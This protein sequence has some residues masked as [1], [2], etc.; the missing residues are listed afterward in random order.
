MSPTDIIIRKFTQNDVSFIKSL[1]PVL[2]EQ[3]RLTWHS[4]K[5]M[6]AFQ[7][8]YI[9]EMLLPT[10]L[11]NITL[12]AEDNTQKLGFVHVRER[13]DEISGE[14]CATVPLLAVVRGLQKRGIGSLLMQEAEKWALG[15]DF[16][17]LHLE[18]FAANSVA[19]AF[20]EKNGFH[21]DTL[22]MIQPLKAKLIL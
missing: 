10:P 12:I 13:I 6:Q 22:H 8:D 16:R 3:A 14:E 5:T 7:D 4:G 18:V 1:S 21:E 19:K 2:A 11:R 20:Y 9:N 17:L 15:N